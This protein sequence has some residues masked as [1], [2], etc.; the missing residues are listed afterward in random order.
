MLIIRFASLMRRL[1]SDSFSSSFAE[2]S[3]SIGFPLSST[4]SPPLT[5]VSSSRRWRTSSTSSSLKSG[6]FSRITF[7]MSVLVMVS[8]V[9]L[10]LM[11]FTTSSSCKIEAFKSSNCSSTIIFVFSLDKGFKPSITRVRAS[12]G[13]PSSLSTSFTVLKCQL[14][15]ITCSIRSDAVMAFRKSFT[16][17]FTSGWLASGIPIMF[18]NLAVSLPSQSRVHLPI[19]CTTSVSEPRTPMVRHSSHHC[20][21]KP[22]LAVPRAMI[23]STSS[24]FFIRCKYPCTRL[25]V[26]AWSS[27]RSA[28]F[29]SLP[30]LVLT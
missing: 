20:Q 7:G 23:I 17:T 27:T 10:P 26:S 3:K 21:S 4:T 13:L 2:A 5:R 29:S 14:G 11:A 9:V 15:A 12:S 18:T 6:Y 8:A 28:T 25:R 22:S 24:R 30:S 1:P 16:A 19:I